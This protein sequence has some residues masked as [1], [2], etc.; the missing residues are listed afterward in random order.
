MKLTEAQKKRL[1]EMAKQALAEHPD[2]A[3]KYAAIGRK[4]LATMEV[5]KKT[6]DKR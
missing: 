4:Y 5:V 3:E 1:S 2:L 6:E